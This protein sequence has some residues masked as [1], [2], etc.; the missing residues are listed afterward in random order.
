MHVRFNGFYFASDG[1]YDAL[2][3]I[4]HLQ[5][6]IYIVLCFNVMLCSPNLEFLYSFSWFGFRPTLKQ[7]DKLRDAT[8]YPQLTLTAALNL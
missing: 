5:I 8:N 4:L 6:I 1:H 3:D 2:N 7:L